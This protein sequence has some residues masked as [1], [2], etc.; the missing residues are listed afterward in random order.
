MAIQNF[1]TKILTIKKEKERT[2]ALKE[3]N[4]KKYQQALA[5]VMVDLALVDSTFSYDEHAFIFDKLTEK[6]DLNKDQKYALIHEAEEL[7][8]TSPDLDS[9]GLALRE[10]IS[11][12]E[13][14]AVIRTLDQLSAVDRERSQYETKLRQR[15]ERLLAVRV[16][17]PN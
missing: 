15:Y 10:L 8:N 17:E 11:C 14:E 1:I 16:A 7:V 2:N 5:V 3:E 6:F 9:Y 13:R 4:L 12:D